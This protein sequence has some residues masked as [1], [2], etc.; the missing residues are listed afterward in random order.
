MADQ[1]YKFIFGP[2]PSWR[3]GVSLGI[4]PVSKGRKICSFDCVYCQLGK[5]G[6]LT[7][8]RQCF[9]PCVDIINELTPLPPLSIDYITFSGAGEPT[10]AVNLGEMI[11]AVKRIRRE[12]V[13]V[14]TNSSL[15]DRE[16]VRADL[17]SA[18]LVVAKIDAAS[19]D[20]FAQVC[21]PIKTVTFDRVLLGLKLLKGIYKGRLA[22][23]IMFVDQN[24]AVAQNI[25]KIV[26][27][28]GPDEVHI[29]TPLRPCAVTPL[30]A[31]ELSELEKFFDGLN[32]VS[33]YRAQKKKVEA[34][35]P[36]D[37]LKRRGKI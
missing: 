34:L 27:D 28:I 21:R 15:L 8:E 20:I 3:L 9:I 24:K 32:V 4:D 5:T 1:N 36:A 7:D 31:S 6:F 12:K 19:Q 30:S 35:S 10:L 37:T 11:N 23:Q 26:R 22:L 2:V 33:V 18:D 13:A 25:A 29:N 16:D 17:L 14:I